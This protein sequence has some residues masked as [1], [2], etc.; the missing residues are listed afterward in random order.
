MGVISLSKSKNEQYL[1]K[2][3]T[4]RS[5]G[6]TAQFSDGNESRQ[7]RKE[8]NFVKS[9][10][11]KNDTY[12]II[13]GLTKL[14]R[15]CIKAVEDGNN[16]GCILNHFQSVTKDG[17]LYLDNA[18]KC[19]QNC[20][21]VLGLKMDDERYN[22][23]QALWWGCKEKTSGTKFSFNWSIPTLDPTR[24]IDNMCKLC[25]SFAHGFSSN[26]L[27]KI[28]KKVKESNVQPN[29]FV[30][31]IDEFNPNAKFKG[32]YN[33]VLKIYQENMQHLS[34]KN[35]RKFFYYHIILF[36]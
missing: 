3:K 24:S 19:V 35:P 5:I 7:K 27:D 15:N 26:T 9:E 31:L 14:R 18:I 20:R 36:L 23:I 2:K 6:S 16:N 13:N 21:N 30:P 17:D 4:K 11:S 32:T 12:E 8:D 22:A 25:F 33:D 29:E 10:A 1:S 28:S 34:L